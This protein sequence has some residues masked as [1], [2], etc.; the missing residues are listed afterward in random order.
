MN[1]APIL[2]KK[3]FAILG[4]ARS[5]VTQWPF[6]IV[7]YLSQRVRRV[8]KSQELKQMIRLNII[9]DRRW[10]Y[11]AKIVTIAST[12]KHL[13]PGFELSRP[14]L[15]LKVPYSPLRCEYSQTFGGPCC[16]TVRHYLNRISRLKRN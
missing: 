7:T 9:C 13:R 16:S 4:L 8:D 14:S 5:E 3:C 2:Q 6:L 1:M 11:N 15:I 10:A 12:F